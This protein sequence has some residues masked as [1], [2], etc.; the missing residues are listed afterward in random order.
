LGDQALAQH[1]VVLDHQQVQ[2][3]KIGRCHP[4]KL[5]SFWRKGQGKWAR[6]RAMTRRADAQ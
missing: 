3:G 4:G 5:G 1:E 6:R 2:T